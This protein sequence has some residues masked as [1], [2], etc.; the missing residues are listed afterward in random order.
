M[1]L[2]LMMPTNHLMLYR[3]FSSCPQSFP[4]SRSFL[5]HQ[6]SSESSLHI[7]WPKYWSFSI[8]PSFEYSGLISF[9]ID[10][11]DLLT[12]QGT[13]KSLLQYH[14]SKTLILCCSALFMVQLSHLCMTAGQ[15]IVLT[16]LTFVGKVMCLLFNLLSRSIR[17]VWCDCSLAQNCSAIL[18]WLLPDNNAAAEN[19]SKYCYSH[20]FSEFWAQAGLPCVVV[21]Q[22][23][24]DWVTE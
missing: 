18:S 5:I 7:R 11:F 12:V 24:L 3:P 2:E 23:L 19:N 13:L 16:I 22:S 10:W 9:G 21:V 20:S 17:S 14:N 6:L 15:T 8:S 4:A 1:F